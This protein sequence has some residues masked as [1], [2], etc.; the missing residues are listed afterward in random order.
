MCSYKYCTCII[1]YIKY[2]DYVYIIIRNITYL[3][4]YQKLYLSIVWKFVKMFVTNKQIN[5][6]DCREQHTWLIRP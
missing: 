1:L 6:N 3:V 4:Y 5:G 2:D